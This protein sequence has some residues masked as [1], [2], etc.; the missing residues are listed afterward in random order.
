MAERAITIRPETQIGEPLPLDRNPAGIYL[1]GLAESG[2]RSM[3]S[4]L[5]TI[6]GLVAGQPCDPLAFPWWRLEY[7]H[8]SAIMAELARRYAPA[9]A[10]RARAALRGVL[11]ECFRLKLM[12][13]EAYQS[14]IDIRPVRGSTLG[15]GRALTRGE[16]DLMRRACEEDPTPAGFRDG[17]ILAVLYLSGVRRSELVALDMADYNP[18]SGELRVRRG[19]GNKAR[20]TYCESGAGSWVGDWLQVRGPSPG[21]LFC[22]IARGNWILVDR[23]LSGQ[24]IWR[25]LR[26]RAQQAGVAP[27]GV[28]D[29]RRTFVSD[30]LESGEDLS[31]VAGLAGH[32][33]VDTTRL[34]DERPE[35][36]RRKAA[37]SLHWPR[38]RPR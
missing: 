35:A 1:R 25:M 6:A 15:K 22:R 32:A 27:M 13:A 7:A 30:L 12:S 2:A 24:A 26:K 5:R 8:T 20:L 10:N 14:A 38:R 37:G 36:A 4:V 17:A 19:K 23:R 31:L 34:Y 18:L 21:P 33:S 16:L 9:S 11:R 29:F 3:Y 28:H